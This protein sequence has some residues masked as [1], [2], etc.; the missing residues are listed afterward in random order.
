MN[1][2]NPI[3]PNIFKPFHNIIALQTTRYGGNSIGDY[4]SLNLGK[5][6]NDDPQVVQSN[7]DILKKEIGIS[8]FALSHQIHGDQI[9]EAEKLGIYSGFDAIITQKSNLFVGVTVADCCPILIYDQ[10]N[11][12]I[13]A[14]HAGWKG[15][16]LGIVLKTLQLSKN[17]YS[18][19]PK[20]CY[21][22]IGACI[23]ERNFEVGNDVADNFS[24]KYKIWDEKRNKFL[25]NLKEA[26][27]D[28]CREFGIPNHQIEISKL[29]TFEDDQLLFSHRKSGGFT[30]RM[31]CGIAIKS[32]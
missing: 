4:F 30:G 19:D 25:V 14:I 17:K 3:I 2:F 7:Y 15:T 8:D 20:D 5:N 6:T 10:K 23:S 1:T 32:N 31:L 21:V 27:T 24:P 13:A 26:N 28:Q 12:V 22:Y 9:L 18:T 29:C 16:I 11:N